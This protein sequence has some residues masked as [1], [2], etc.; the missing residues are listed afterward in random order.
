MDPLSAS[1]INM[2]EFMTSSQIGYSKSV[3]IVPGNKEPTGLIPYLAY[4]S[5]Q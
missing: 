5:H 1:C 4:P 3:A 2:E